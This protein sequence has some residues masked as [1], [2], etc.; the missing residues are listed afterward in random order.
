[1]HKEKMYKE[2]V[3]IIQAMSAKISRSTGLDKDDIECQGNLIF[4]ECAERYD[5]SRGEFSKYLTNALYFG[6]FKYVKEILEFQDI[7]SADYDNDIPE[8]KSSKDILKLSVNP[9][10]SK[11]VNATFEN[12][13]PDSKYIMGLT[14][15]PEVEFKTEK[16]HSSRI[17]KHKLKK[18]LREQGW[19]YQRIFDAFSEI[20]TVVE[21]R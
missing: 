21:A 15:D 13:S 20:K 3:E 8:I 19:K 5:Q 4:C 16:Y 6:L 1:M 11:I 12:L 2:S 7:T 17:T 10:Y 18:Y 14:L 9:D